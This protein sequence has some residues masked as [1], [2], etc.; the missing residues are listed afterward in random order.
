M[1]ISEKRPA[2][3]LKLPQV[4]RPV[5]VKEQV[6]LSLREQLMHGQP[7]PNGRVIEKQL[8]DALGV[9]R[10]PV[11]EA[12]S[13]LASEGLLVATRH[14]YKVPDFSIDDVVHLFEVRLLL[15]P[16]AA[17]Q[18]ADNGSD[19]GLATM[20]RAIAEEKSAH[21]A[22]AVTRFLR[23]H[24]AFREAWLKRARNPLL[25]ESLGR[26]LHSLQAIR[27]RTMSDGLMRDFM[28]RS[29]EALLAAIEAG[30]GDEAERVQTETIE[31]FQELVRERIFQAAAAGKPSASVP[32]DE[33]RRKRLSPT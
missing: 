16:V 20:H 21:A 6:Y 8:T 18:A 12:L 17:R 4:S 15:E 26:T 13:R 10:T 28:I 25:L 29:H 32:A 23:A 11:R 3:A 31:R 14:G 22:G 9:S 30:K 7:G 24:S 5:T 19:A 33:G 1:S 27:R 2:A